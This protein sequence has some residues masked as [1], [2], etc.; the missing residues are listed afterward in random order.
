MIEANERNLQP[1]L[2]LRVQSRE[3]GGDHHLDESLR[4]HNRYLG[5][6]IKEEDY[7]THSISGALEEK[8]ASLF[9]EIEFQKPNTDRERA[10]TAR[11]LASIGVRL[12]ETLFPK[13]LRR[14]LWSL[15]E[16]QPAPSLLL[17]SNETKI[18]WELIRLRDPD[19]S[20]KRMGSP[21]AG[22]PD[23]ENEI[24]RHR[25]RYLVEAFAFTRWLR[26]QGQTFELPLSR[27]GLLAP[28]DTDL[29]AAEGEQQ[30]FQELFPDAEPLPVSRLELL[31]RLEAAEH[32]SL[33][34]SG[35]GRKVSKNSDFN[36]ILLAGD[37]T[38][39]A[40]D[41]GDDARNLGRR[42]PWVFL[43]ACQTAQSLSVLSGVGGFADAF[44]KAGA[45]AF[46]G[47]HWEVRDKRAG[48]FAL[49]IYNY[50]LQGR[51]LGAAV[52]LARDWF[53]NKYPGDPTFLAY[54]VYGH[55][56][57]VRN[58]AASRWV[59]G[60]N[61]PLAIPAQ[62]WS[63]KDDH[64]A[65]LLRAEYRVVDFHGREREMEELSEWSQEDRSC[66]VRLLTGQGGMGKTRLLLEAAMQHA[67]KGWLA[68]FL[69]MG[70]A[71]RAPTEA[72]DVLTGHAK[73]LFLVL[74]YAET[75]RDLLV[76][77]LR[78]MLDA[79]RNGDSPPMRLVLLAR[80]EG[81]WWEQLKSEGEGVGDFLQGPGTSHFSLQPL[82][83]RLADRVESFRH[84]GTAF[85]AALG[86][87]PPP[88]PEP[89]IFGEE[90]YERVLFIHMTALTAVQ[91]KK[92]V[93]D[94]DE[95][96]DYILYR[97][98]RFWK[99]LAK[100]RGLPEGFDRQLGRAMAAITMSGGTETP[101]EAV[102]GLQE[103]EL[104]AEMEPKLLEKIVQVL[105]DSYPGDKT[106]IAPLQP[107]LLGEHLMHREL[108][109][110]AEDLLGLL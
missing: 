72:W 38:L 19:E 80:G 4:V 85:A 69:T 91:K 65:G 87:A 32:D 82:A 77:L 105:H 93:V 30:R 98:R 60:K 6:E 68:G 15:R 79:K 18:P 90:I 20:E 48:D 106:Y 34:F 99:R 37:E 86:N 71:D 108:E 61:I 21:I 47:T 107:D 101:L 76:P 74:D 94:R 100:E 73:P 78:G 25:S 92:L 58:E 16:R 53:S 97:E 52:R 63:E 70:E 49:A 36:Q 12:G 26:D 54:A 62:T 28:S 102:S 88:N 81:D 39:Y 11:S 110:G 46:L 66:A 75:R 55:P 1:D 44:L 51:E 17:L 59:V 64:P 7:P 33:H 40:A 24:D 27:M 5:L 89:Q 3:S 29:P 41:L 14:R 45:G 35:H 104:F 83:D 31:Q 84:A 50:F 56:L 2:V 9:R 13:E 67:E 22:D 23:D 8:L 109:S 43:N 103:L 57:A 10:L 96:F 42:S 95:V